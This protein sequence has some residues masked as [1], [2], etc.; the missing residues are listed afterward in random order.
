MNTEM[1]DIK[2]EFKKIDKLT[3][4]QEA[5]M[6]KYVDKWIKVGTQLEDISDTEAF[7]IVSDFRGII[8]LPT[9]VPMLW[10]KNPIECWVLCFLAQEG[11]PFIELET[12][13][14]KVFNGNPKKWDIP[15]ASLPFNDISLVST[16]AF[17]DFM[18]NEVKV[19]IEKELLEKYKRWE[20]TS[21]LFAIYP[22]D[23]ITIICRRPTEIHL[24][25]NNVLHKDE[26]AALV[27]EGAGEFKVYSLNGVTVP[28]YLALTPAQDLKVDDYL[29][30][31]NA[32]VKAEF[33]RKAGVE[34][35]LSLGKLVDS[36]ENYAKKSHEWWHK[37]Q[38][39]LWDMSALFSSLSYAPYL[40]MLNPTTKIWHLE[41]V[42]PKCRTVKDALKERFGGRDMKIIAAA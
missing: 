20:A 40:K 18:I 9:N 16:F 4:E 30:E 21:A 34:K 6:P 37:S 39:E 3:P 38:Y 5:A 36:Y 31:T 19:P 12:E 14:H 15:K 13:M 2:A 26:G 25:Q 29:K 35:F 24:N 7:E 10:G 11:I 28:D 32:D 23:N 41:G 27:F 22:L 8:D 42:S 17:Y 33:I 1:N